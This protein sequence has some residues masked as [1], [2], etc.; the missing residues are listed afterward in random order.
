MK[1][2][3][4]LVGIVL[5]L[6]CGGKS[7]AAMLRADTGTLTSAQVADGASANGVVT[8]GARAIYVEYV[9]TGTATVTI[10]QQL[11]GGTNF[12]SVS[13]S[14]SAA[15]AILKMEYPSGVIRTKVAGCSNC[16]VTTKYEMVF[17]REYMDKRT[18]VPPGQ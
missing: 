17:D 12:Q 14:A 15:N 8:T 5:L 18:W 9:I 11:L 4:V 2:L 16:S 10:E 1:K 3:L 6:M 7:Y 13:G